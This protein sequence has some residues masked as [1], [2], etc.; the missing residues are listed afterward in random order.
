MIMQRAPGPTAAARRMRSLHPGDAA[1]AAGHAARAADVLQRP[2]LRATARG[3][4][5]SGF[6]SCADLGA[7]GGRGHHPVVPAAARG[8]PCALRQHERPGTQP[9]LPQHSELPIARSGTGIRI[10]GKRTWRLASCASAT[11]DSPLS[12]LLL[13][14][15]LCSSQFSRCCNW[16]CGCFKEIRRERFC[17]VWQ[18]WQSY[19]YARF[20]C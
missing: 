18:T 3:L 20:C 9:A 14:S 2:G 13:R 7:I 16:Q 15:H 11:D 6:S 4:C 8:V 10:R 17:S 1:P 5:E 19:G 12:A